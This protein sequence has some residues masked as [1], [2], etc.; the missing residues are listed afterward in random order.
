[1]TEALSHTSQLLPSLLISK[2]GVEVLWYWTNF[3]TEGR[4]GGNRYCF[5][6]LTSQTNLR[7]VKLSR[8]KSILIL[9]LLLH[10]DNPLN[11]DIDFK[12][13]MI[14]FAL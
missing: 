5:K 11:K 12:K 3:D 2:G 8:F 4:E 1:M 9:S 6:L 10:F 14:S 7:P 13:A